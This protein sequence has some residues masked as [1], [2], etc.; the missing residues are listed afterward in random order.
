MGGEGPHVHVPQVWLHGLH[1][2][3]AQHGRIGIVCGATEDQAQRRSV[4]TRSA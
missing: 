1:K 4:R 2:Q 3:E